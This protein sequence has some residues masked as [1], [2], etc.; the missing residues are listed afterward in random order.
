MAISAVILTFNEEKHIARCIN[1]LK[2]SV[3]HVYVLD[4]FSTDDTL[5]ILAE[6]SGFVTVKQNKFVNHAFQF[7][8]ALTLFDIKTDWVMRID[9]D[10]IIDSD[11]NVWLNSELYR[12]D[13]SVTGVS[14]NRHMTFMN[15]PLCFG[16]MSSYWMLRIWRNG[17][18]HCEQRWMDEHM[19]L[20]SGHVIR[21]NGKLIDDNLN[22]LSWW[23]HK[24]VD[25][26]TREA[27]DVLIRDTLPDEHFDFIRVCK[28]FYNNL[29]LF[30]RPFFYF[31][32][33][34]FFRLGF[35]DGRIGFL[36][37]FLQGFWYRMMVDAK[38]FEIKREAFL[39]NTTIKDVIKNKYGYEI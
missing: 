13:S 28:K 17:Y 25:Y 12:T 2:D 19:V 32:Y 36:W 26:S 5:K 6:F 23:A 3:D 35:L 21:A 24:H 4:S 7:N 34:Y 27:I 20:S 1:S 15:K 30:V 37:N 9:A 18:A 11:L 10:E 16:G 8:M 29:P 14:V 38:I 39:S 33:R 22:N 31:V